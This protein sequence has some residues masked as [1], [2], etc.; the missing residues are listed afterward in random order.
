MSFMVNNVARLILPILDDLLAAQAVLPA[1]TWQRVQMLVREH[2]PAI[3]LAP[4]GFNTSAKIAVFLDALR[5]LGPAL[6]APVAAS[7]AAGE[8]G[9]AASGDSALGLDKKAAVLARLVQIVDFRVYDNPIALAQ[10]VD[11]EVAAHVDRLTDAERVAWRGL[12]QTRQQ[13][14]PVNPMGAAEAYLAQVEALLGRYPSLRKMLG[15]KLWHP[16]QRHRQGNVTP[17]GNIAYPVPK[18]LVETVNRFANVHFPAKVLASQENIPLVVHVAGEYQEGARGMAGQV[19]MSL[20]VGELRIV[21]LAEGFRLVRSIGGRGDR[22]TPAVRMVD[23]KEREDC[24]PVVYFLTPLSV[25]RHTLTLDFY[26]KN[27]RP[28]LNLAFETEVV[29]EFSALTMLPPAELEAMPLSSPERG[30]NAPA[31]DLELRVTLSG[32]ILSY[33]LHSPG[34]GDYNHREVGKVDLLV[35]PL[36]F[37]K[38]TFDTLNTL[39]KQPWDALSVDE[40][41]NAQQALADI[42]NDLWRQLFPE[43]EAAAFRQ[44]YRTIRQRYEGRGVLI[45][46]D[47]T[48]IPWEVVKPYEIDAQGRIEFNDEPFCE[49]FRI[50]RWLAGRPVPDQVKMQRAAWV[51]PADNLAAVKKES[52][53]F[54]NLYNSEWQLVSMDGPLT[55]VP[56]VDQKL[57]GAEIQLFH[58]ACHGS[59]DATDP[60]DSKLKLADGFFTPKKIG[61]AAEA[62]LRRA[63]PLLFLNACHGGRTGIGLTQIGG[64]APRL[65]KAGVS[66]FIGGLWEVNDSLAAQ[67][68]VEFYDRLWGVGARAGQAP[69]SLGQAFHEARMAIKR[70]APGNPTWLAYVLYGD[71][72]GEVILGA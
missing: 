16:D 27:D 10:R 57:S 71:P 1:G 13:N 40:R 54:K 14:A 30:L 46:S 53:Y 36:T 38:P 41:A 60:S 39:A 12:S 9:G 26:Q 48:W 68:T 29:S 69:L 67:F 66:A 52:D 58:F 70:L 49:R 33:Y 34:G 25:G 6:P 8:Q 7:L 11:A 45:M 32:T 72:Y 63:K 31:P 65:I 15:E 28:I 4:E 61:V 59:F 56:E 17:A 19:K 44:E 20:N 43:E 5:L 3:A 22:A 18:G 42:G 37:L 2:G 47:E 24:E 64:W 21:L 35:D 23:V 50:A 55:K 62:G 51:A